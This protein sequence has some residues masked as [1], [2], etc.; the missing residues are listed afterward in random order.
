MSSAEPS[1]VDELADI[2][3]SFGTKCTDSIVVCVDLNFPGTDGSHVDDQL[4]ADLD[5]FG[6]LQPVDSPT[7]GDNLGY[8]GV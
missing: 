6:L 1:F 8:F 7:R 4:S 2:L 3:A 5:S